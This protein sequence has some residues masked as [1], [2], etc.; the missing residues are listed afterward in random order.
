MNRFSRYAV[1]YM[2]A[3]PLADFGA[4]WL[5]WD[6]AAGAAVPQPQVAGLDMAAVTAAARRYGFHATMK[7]PF[8]LAEGAA[9]ADLAAALTAF[10]A[11]E[12]PV[13]LD[14]RLARLDGFLALIAGSAALS[15]LESRLVPA[16]DPLRAPLTEAEVAR[17]R[18]ERLTPQQRALLDR[19]GYPFVLDQFRFHMTLTGDL[20]EPTAARAEAALREALAAV[21][22]PPAIDALTLMGEDAEGRFHSILRAPLGQIRPLS[23]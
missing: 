16:I 11:A 21:P 14:L 12:A 17:R 9:E 7:A 18:P 22:L 6:A 23:S 4:A 15:G 13:P 20:D 1:Y 5:G 19:W 2:P 10:C 3:G 8:R